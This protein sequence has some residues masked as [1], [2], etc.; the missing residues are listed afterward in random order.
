MIHAI[1]KKNS[2]TTKR[3]LLL[4]NRFSTAKHSIGKTFKFP[5]LY[6]FVN[7]KLRMFFFFKNSHG[8][9]LQLFLTIFFF[10]RIQITGHNVEK[11]HLFNCTT[12]ALPK[13]STMVLYKDTTVGKICSDKFI[14]WNS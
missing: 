9:L 7:D 4:K 1:R 11:I 6:V 14:K 12:F 3:T 10:F 5:H 2:T 8:L 13:P